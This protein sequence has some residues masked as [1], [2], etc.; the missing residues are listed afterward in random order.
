MASCHI[1]ELEASLDLNQ[2]SFSLGGKAN[3]QDITGQHSYQVIAGYHNKLAGQL[4][5]AFLY[6]HYEYPP[7]HI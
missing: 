3:S 4:Y 2:L 7:K 1:P 6:G 5:G